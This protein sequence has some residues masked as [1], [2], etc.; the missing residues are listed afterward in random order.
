[1]CKRTDS[2]ELM[3]G[4]DG[5]DDWF[6]FSC[7]K[8]PEKFKELV[9]SFY[10][11]YCQAGI[12]GPSPQVTDGRVE[13]R[14]TIWKRKCRLNGCFHACKDESKYCSKEHGQ[15]YMK[16]AVSRLK[17][18]GMGRDEQERLIKQILSSSGQSAYEFQRYG[19]SPFANEEVTRKENPTLYDK[20][21]SDDQRLLELK[22]KQSEL[23]E[24][25]LPEVNKKLESLKIYLQWVENVN[26]SLFSSG[27]HHEVSND[28]RQRNKSANRKQKRSICGYTSHWETIPCSEDEFTTQYNDESTTIQGVCTKLRCNKHADWS[29]MLLEQYNDQLRS[30]QSHQDRL[31]LLIKARKDQ[32]MIQFHEQLLRNKN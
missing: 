13:V 14:R 5:C 21:V 9:F 16:Q 32:L 25:T 24:K 7:L 20:V 23:Q 19:E 15:E 8:I 2:G 22:S 29:S 31:E 28:N 27:N 4:C 3:V 1:M 10:C 6:H 30:L 11:P 18:A 17:V 12:T 26:H